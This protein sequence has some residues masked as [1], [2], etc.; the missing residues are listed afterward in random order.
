[1]EGFHNWKKAVECCNRRAISECLREA[2]SR[3]RS[4]ARVSIVDQMNEGASKAKCKDRRMF[5]KVLSS[6]QYL[7]RQ[8]LALRGHKD[9]ESN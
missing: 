8:G 7:L 1:M 9:E 6:L 2:I 3:I 4:L 5:I